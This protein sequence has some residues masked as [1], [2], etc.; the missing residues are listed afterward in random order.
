IRDENAPDSSPA[1]APWSCGLEGPPMGLSP[2]QQAATGNPLSKPASWMLCDLRA[3]WRPRR[4]YDRPVRL[5]NGAQEVYVAWMQV[6]GLSSSPTR[7]GDRYD[8]VRLLL[9]E[10]LRAVFSR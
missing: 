6:Y 8:V 2:Q 9:D 10:Y 7:E 5:K 1:Q 4:R 3:G